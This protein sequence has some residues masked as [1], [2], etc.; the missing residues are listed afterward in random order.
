MA[1]LPQPGSD[2]G[3]WGA[4]LNEY[5]SQSHNSD[6]S[7]KSEIISATHI[8][9]ATITE[10]QLD[11]SVQNKLNTA[12]SGNVADGTITT[13]KLHDDAVTNVKVAPAAAIDQSKIAN[14]TADLAAKSDTGHTHTIAN[15]TNLQTTLDGK[16]ATSHTHTAVQISDS[17]A[18]GRSLI[19]AADA[20]AARSAIGAGTG[21]SNLT[22]GTT[23][24]TAKA[25]D[26]QPSWTDVTSKPTTFTPAAHAHA[27]A[28]LTS[29]TVASARLGSGTADGTTF[30]RGDGTWAT[31]AGGSLPSQT[32]QSGKFLTTNGTAAS[33]ATVA[34]SGTVVQYIA[35]P[36]GVAAT[37]TAA[38]QA[39]HDAL[40]NTGGEIRLQ[41]G[42]YFLTAAG[43]TIT[44]TVRLV[45]TG[46]SSLSW[47]GPGGENGSGTMLYSDAINAV[48][49][50]ISADSCVIEDI[51]LFNNYKA[52]GTVTS[53]SGLRFT[54]A[55]N[56][57]VNRVLICAYYDNIRIDAGAYYNITNCQIWAPFRY[58]LWIKNADGA[59]S[60]DMVVSGCKFTTVG[61]IAAP[62][63]GLRWESGAGL[64]LTDCKFN[65]NPA[66]NYKYITQLDLAWDASM[67]DAGDM[68]VQ[69]NSFENSSSYGIR[70]Y[71]GTAGASIMNYAQIQGNEFQNNGVAIAVDTGWNGT[72]IDSN[73]FTSGQTGISL[74]AGSGPTT[75]GPNNF[76][77]TYSVAKTT[78]SGS[79]A[80]GTQVFTLPA[81]TPNGTLAAVVPAPATAA[82]T[83]VPGQIAYDAN[84][85][86]IC[87][88]T[89]T[90]RRSAHATW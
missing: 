42:V 35:A 56:V 3:T 82:S 86:Y 52:T 12:G 60:G 75:V 30:L 87:T 48:G 70:M 68:F 25:G 14:L 20:A 90:W 44:K 80:L 6:G 38:I 36:T 46:P 19:A 32:G 18:T 29:G 65:G 39:A 61:A 28:D 58:G 47:S 85:V 67:G 23:G 59:D 9:D 43:V 84:Y 73:Y 64:R 83:G 41:A 4:I 89:N 63:A 10:T 7:L 1:R 55:S 76:F 13:V 53:G 27:G 71:T 17:T 37:D 22:L 15:V 51:G 77:G 81:T 78:V 88:G 8:Q 50:T 62:V 26:Y 33:W 74:L 16:A 79:V 34:T 11:A 57:N 31:P 54:E 72:F 40:P 24:A 45:G 21:T 49:I 5:L 2:N 66:G 69:N